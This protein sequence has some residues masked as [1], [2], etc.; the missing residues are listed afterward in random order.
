MISTSDKA[1][2][3]GME[4]RE[5]H[6][7][8][9][10]QMAMGLVKEAIENFKHRG[11]VYI[12]VEPVDSIGGFSVETIV[13]A[14]GGTPDPLIEAL[15]G[16]KIRGA[17]GVVGC[18]NP[19]I[20]QDYGHV[21]LTR[22]LIENDILVVDTGCAAIA[23]AKA[24]FKVAEAIKYAGP[25]LSEVCGALGIPPVLHMGSCVDNVRILMLAS[26]LA[27]ALDVDISDLP[28]A[29]AAP[30][31]Y[32]EKAVSIG[33]YFVASGVYTVL[34]P[35]PPITGSQNVVKLLTEGLNDVVGATFAVEPDPE[36]AALLICRHIEEKRE[37]L[38]LPA[39]N[40]S[41]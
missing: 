36:K 24:G 7:H 3:P 5:F 30:E 40:A 35:M 1:R 11:E 39:L 21:T 10:R 9:A 26:A 29:G 19:K 8:N 20:K 41:S 18:N 4:H 31:W 14:L 12:P 23:N 38:G 34:G 37:K 22:R 6:P 13:D 28:L 17:V 25:G 27:N 15:K 32:S 33:A 2:F 16:G